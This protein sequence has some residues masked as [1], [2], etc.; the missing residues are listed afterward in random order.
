MK[1]QCPVCF[2][3]FG[4][5]SK[6][7][8]HCLSSHNRNVLYGN[9]SKL[10]IREMVKYIRSF[11]VNQCYGCDVHFASR[12]ETAKHFESFHRIE[13]FHC[14][15]CDHI[16]WRKVTSDSVQSESIDLDC[17]SRP[18]HMGQNTNNNTAIVIDLTVD[19]DDADSSDGE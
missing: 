7:Q 13:V 12:V 6:M 14:L 18:W 15:W 4:G 11:K 16:F 1:Y 3:I 8:R 2:K 5:W 17:P 10:P 19:S 9:I